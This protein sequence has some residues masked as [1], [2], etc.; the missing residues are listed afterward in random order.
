M[1][2]RPRIV[3]RLRQVIALR[4]RAA[5]EGEREAADRA[6]LRLL[7]RLGRMPEVDPGH[8]RVVVGGMGPLPE[9]HPEV[10]FPEEAE[11]REILL[12]W[13]RGAVDRRQL[14]RWAGWLVD[15]LVLPEVP[16][17]DPAALQT[18]II[19]QLAIRRRCPIRVEDVPAILGF[20]E[21]APREGLLAWL[22][23]LG[24]QAQAAR[25][26]RTGTDG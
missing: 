16:P 10:S 2:D 11:L 3:R 15:K 8:S 20:L 4:D 6:R 23:W 21:M 18:E 26:R 7:E 13:E 24:E 1:S 14:A 19:L 5:T 22:E 12:A 17:D 9:S 25:P